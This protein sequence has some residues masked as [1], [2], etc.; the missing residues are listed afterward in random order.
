MVVVSGFTIGG[1]GKY[2]IYHTMYT[3]VTTTLAASTTSNERVR[4]LVSA[5]VWRLI[6]WYDF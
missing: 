6:D 3:M 2:G 4:Q 1:G 5:M